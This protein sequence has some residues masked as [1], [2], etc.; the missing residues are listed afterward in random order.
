ME[1]KINFKKP[2]IGMGSMLLRLGE[3]V[4]FYRGRARR[5]PKD[6]ETTFNTIPIRYITSIEI[7][8][9]NKLDKK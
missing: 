1:V 8:E 5:I 3:K 2:G 4:Q 7:L 9:D 6:E